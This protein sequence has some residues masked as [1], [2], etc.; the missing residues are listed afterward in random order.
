MSS[1]MSRVHHKGIE[2][3]QSS[4]SILDTLTSRTTEQL[5]RNK[6]QVLR[7]FIK[8]RTLEDV[9]HTRLHFWWIQWVNKKK[10][11]MSSLTESWYN[12]FYSYKVTCHVLTYEIQWSF[13][14]YFLI[15]FNSTCENDNYVDISMRDQQTCIIAISHL[16][17]TNCNCWHCCT[18]W[19]NCHHQPM[20][21]SV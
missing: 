10:L 14:I 13:R 20:F 3:R 8:Q 9:R 11:L 17:D 6:F 2:S 15:F 5:D 21:C 12:H 1:S 7:I 19:W 4:M 16:R 18:R